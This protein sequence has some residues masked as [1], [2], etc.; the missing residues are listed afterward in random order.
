MPMYLLTLAQTHGQQTSASTGKRLSS[1]TSKSTCRPLCDGL[2]GLDARESRPMYICRASI[3]QP[4]PAS[5]KR[6][7]TR[8]LV[9]Q[10]TTVAWLNYDSCGSLL[11]RLAQLNWL[12][13]PLWS[14]RRRESEHLRV[15]LRRHLGHVYSTPLP[16]YAAV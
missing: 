8:S 10:H 3:T 12:Q 7:R 16:R 6:H 1:G 4:A 9:A 13:V 5:W 11:L 2:N 14:D 15:L